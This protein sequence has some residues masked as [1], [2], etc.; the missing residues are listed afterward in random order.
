AVPLAPLAEE[1]TVRVG[2][3][4]GAARV[5][6]GGGG[7]LRVSARDG[8]LLARL[9][10]GTA[11][12]EVLPK[13]AGLGL[14]SGARID[15]PVLLVSAEP[16]GTVRVDGREYRGHAVLRRD[17]KGVT[18]VNV[19]GIEDYLGGVVGYELGTR[20]P[21]DFEALRAQ[22]V[23]ART[24][25]LKNMGRW[26][27]QGF[28]LRA[29]VADQV[30]GGITAESEVVRRA[31]RSTRGEVLTHGGAL[32]DAFFFS[33]CGG[34]TAEGTEV[35]RGANRSY[36]RSVED[37]G[38]G[39]LAWCR[40]SSRFRWQE[41]WTGEALGAAL[42]RSLPPV[43]PVHADEVEPVRDVRVLRTGP[44]GRVTELLLALRGR[45]VRLDGPQARQVLRRPGGEAI[46]SSA[47]TAHATRRDGR[48][49]EL[50]VD[51][52]GWGHGV[53]F[54]QWGAIGRGRAGARAPEILAA[55]FTGTSLVRRY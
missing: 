8:R 23:I 30:Y 12:V 54:C 19:V 24:Y 3:A 11:A 55:Y 9:P 38:P 18:A 48:L 49:T 31:V 35:F 14:S 53:G 47:F 50:V 13:G 40:E 2:L 25:A 21:R 22:A 37:T 20:D 43:V 7:A 10:S 52:Q 51:G 5:A 16:A 15:E 36:L 4:S 28:D 34:R 32:I 41:R 26:N 42:R 45:E 1:P 46:Q 33:T 44:S 39:G 29:S 17:D 6:L 27:A